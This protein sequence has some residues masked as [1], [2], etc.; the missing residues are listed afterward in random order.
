MTSN[1][2]VLLV[3][4][5]YQ[6]QWVKGMRHGYGVRTSAPF[7][8]ASH[9]SALSKGGKEVRS[10]MTSLSKSSDA[11]GGGTTA[12]TPEPTDRRDRRVDDSRGGFV[13]RARSDQ[14]PTR[15][16]SLTEKSLK[17]GLLSVSF[18]FYLRGTIRKSTK[19]LYQPRHARA[20]L[21]CA[22]IQIKSSHLLNGFIN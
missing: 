8:L 9:Y 10:S 17:K 14:A 5:T 13:L 7:G 20:S 21:C 15:R 3:T 18:I 12:P 16:K 11:G 4:G 6:G 2:F 22:R 19:S 1:E